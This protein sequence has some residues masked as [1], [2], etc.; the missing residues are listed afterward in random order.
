MLEK[1]IYS[2][3]H[4]KSANQT[5]HLY[6]VYRIVMCFFFQVTSAN[7]DELVVLIYFTLEHL[8]IDLTNIFSV[9]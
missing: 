4:C 9:E 1:M 5:S 3:L 8:N 7:V 6:E 2:S